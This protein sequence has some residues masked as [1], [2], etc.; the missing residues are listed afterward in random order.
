MRSL[1]SHRGHLIFACTTSGLSRMAP[2]P[3]IRCPA[4]KPYV[5]STFVAVRLAGDA[6]SDSPA[7][8]SRLDEQIIGAADVQHRLGRHQQR[9]PLVGAQADLGEHARL[10]QI[11]AVGDVK[12]HAHRAALLRDGCPD[13][14]DVPG[15]RAGPDN[16][17]GCAVQAWSSCTSAIFCSGTLATTSVVS[18]SGLFE[19]RRID[20]RLLE[21]PLQRIEVLLGQL[22]R[23]FEP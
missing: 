1:R 6:R 20:A 16:H 17:K 7:A 18:S 22:Q 14:F 19:H 3:M 4:S 8:A 21:S 2:R 13:P 10:E 11:L 9:R 15:E 12:Q 5:I 23:R